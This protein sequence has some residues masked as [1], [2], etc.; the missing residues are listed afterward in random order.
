MGDQIPLLGPNE[1]SVSDIPCDQINSG[2][3][4]GEGRGVQVGVSSGTGLLGDGEAASEGEF[5][6][7]DNSD[8]VSS[9]PI[10]GIGERV[11]DSE[12]G[13]CLLPG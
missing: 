11:M 8:L 13:T 4:V 6:G 7:Y 5:V 2:I 9:K 1:V 12:V 3:G 10:T